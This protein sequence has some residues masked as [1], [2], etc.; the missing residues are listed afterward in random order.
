MLIGLIYNWLAGK[1]GGL[2]ITLTEVNTVQSSNDTK[3]TN[4]NS[5]NALDTSNDGEVTT[6][7]N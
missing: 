1:F 5:D 4:N 7:T 6:P 2:E 3:N